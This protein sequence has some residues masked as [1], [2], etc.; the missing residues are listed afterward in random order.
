MNNNGFL[1]IVIL[2]VIGIIIFLLIKN[3]KVFKF[4][5]L[6]MFNGRLSEVV[7]P[8]PLYILQ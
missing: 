5:T 2:F 7:K 6:T 1:V 3:R 8:P 4:D